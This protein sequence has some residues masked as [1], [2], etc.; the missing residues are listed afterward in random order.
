MKIKLTVEETEAFAFGDTN[1]FTKVDQVCDYEGMY[2]DFVN[3]TTICKQDATGKFYALDWNKYTSH[4]GRGEHE[5]SSNEIY[6]VEE[7][8]VVKVTK[9]WKAK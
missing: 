3:C 2:K 1:D 4:Y 5:F 7:V 9:E 6:E 8:E